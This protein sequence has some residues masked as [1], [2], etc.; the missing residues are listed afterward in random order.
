[1]L[2]DLFSGRNTPISVAAKKMGIP[3]W[4]PIDI[5]LDASHDILSDPFFHRLLSLAWSGQIALLIAAPPCRE[6][7]IPGRPPCLQK[8]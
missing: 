3:R 5:T 1:M 8:P 7:S 6:Y 2:L 4:E